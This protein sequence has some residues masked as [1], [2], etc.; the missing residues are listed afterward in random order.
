M[1][2]FGNEDSGDVTEEPLASR[3]GWYGGPSVSITAEPVRPPVGRRLLGEVF[4][5]SCAEPWL[6]ENR[7]LAQRL[8]A[9]GSAPFVTQF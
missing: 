2:V 4:N 7:E 9:P 5:R 3:L 1:Q 6:C 8:L